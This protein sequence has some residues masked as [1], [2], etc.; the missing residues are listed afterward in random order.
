[1]AHERIEGMAVRITTS[2][3]SV[4]RRLMMRGREEREEGGRKGRR[5]GGK[6]VLG[7]CNQDWW[8]SSDAIGED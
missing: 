3:L 7:V 1:M 5:E 6:E 2:H 8:S 4:T